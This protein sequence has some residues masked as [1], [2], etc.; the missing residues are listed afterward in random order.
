M[1]QIKNIKLKATKT[2]TK[3][4]ATKKPAAVRPTTKPSAKRTPA[5]TATVLKAAAPSVAAMT[6]P[7][8]EVTTELIAQRAYILWEKQ[9]CPHGHD[10]A[11]WLL[12]EKQLKQEIQSFTA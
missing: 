1:K 7:R 4:A 3:V 5:A 8:R 6:A 2:A 9:G 11:N 10:L 12:A